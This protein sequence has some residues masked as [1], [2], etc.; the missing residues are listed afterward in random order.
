MTSTT[1]LIGRMPAS[2]SRRFIQSGDSPIVT[3]AT[4]ATKRGQRSGASTTTVAPSIVVDDGPGIGRRDVERQREVRGE[5]ARDAD[6]AHRVG[7]V[8]RDRE[9]EHDVVE[10]EHLAH[11]GAERGVGR[12]L[13]NAVVVVAEAELAGRAQH[14]LRHLTADL[15]ALDLEVA[16]QVRADR[17]ERHDHARFDV[18][19]AAH[20]A[21]RTVAGVDVGEADAIG[22]GMRQDVED[23]RDD[24][25]AD[26]AA[27]L[28][29]PLDLEAELVQR[30]G[31]VG[32]RRLD[33]RE[34]ANPR[35]RCAH[36]SRPQNCAAKRTSPSQRFLTWSTP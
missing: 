5:L 19:R 25:A 29:D 7:A 15:A 11:V 35:E 14:P 30:V 16:G 10:A 21:H 18:R 1:L 20:D 8:G 2:V 22:V 17:R 12:E 28:V 36:R 6:D 31:D 32:D 26:L 3:F 9:I 34:L 23:P 27:G 4:I 24:H 33:R 13:E